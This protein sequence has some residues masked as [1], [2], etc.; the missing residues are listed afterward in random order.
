MNIKKRHALYLMILFVVSGC[1][2]TDFLDESAELFEPRIV[3]TPTVQ[4]I[5]INEVVTYDATYYDSTDTPRSTSFEWESSDSDIVTINADGTATGRQT[6]QARITARAFGVT[7]EMALITVVQDAN[8]IALVDVVP[9]DT[10][11]T[12]GG[13][14]QYSFVATNGMGEVVEGTSVEWATSV[15]SVA[16]IDQNGLLTSLVPG[17]VQVTATVDGIQSAPALLDVFARSRTGS[18]QRAPGTSYN[19]QGTAIIE[20]SDTGLQLRFLD[21]FVVTNGPDLHV[22]LSSENGINA[23]S[24][25]LGALQSPSGAQTYM[26]PG[27]IGMNDFD[28]VVIHCVPFNVSF[29]WAR[30]N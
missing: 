21:N 12:A 18:F 9:A 3:V 22:Y 28:Y 13:E 27:N 14:I 19:V 23:R 10:N 30:I 11:V 6:G 1:I 2:G 25:D 20:Q 4:A 17:A 5:E 24:V 16:Q 7:S 15:D 8:Q 29:G 26:L